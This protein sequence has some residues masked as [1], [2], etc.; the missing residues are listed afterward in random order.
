MIICV[1]GD[2]EDGDGPSEELIICVPGD[3]EDG[4]GPSE[5]LINCVPYLSEFRL[6]FP[7]YIVLSV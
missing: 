3:A 7:L 5:E 4:D 2:A 6:Q 1:P